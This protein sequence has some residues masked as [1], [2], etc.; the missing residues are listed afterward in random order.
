[1]EPINL[2][3]SPFVASIIRWLIALVGGWAV[4]HGFVSAEQLTGLS[5]DLINSL[6]VV[7]AL[8]ALGWSQWQKLH[9]AKQVAAAKGASPAAGGVSQAVKS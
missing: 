2:T 3:P 1:M 7:A 5:P 4:G 6:G 9:Q 8:G